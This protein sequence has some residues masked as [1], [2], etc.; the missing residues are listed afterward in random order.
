MKKLI[1]SPDKFKGTLTSPEI[2]DITEEQFKA[3]FPGLQ[4]IKL[5]IADGGDGTA[6]CF[7]CH[8]GAMKMPCKVSNPFFEL[9]D[10]YYVT[11][12]KT[13]VIETAMYAG[14]ALAGDRKNPLT[15][16]TYGVGQAALEAIKNGAE[17][18]IFAL[19]GS[20]TNDMGCGLLCAMGAKFYDK[21]KNAFIPTGKTLC[22]ICN[23]DTTELQYNTRNVEFEVM[24]DIDNVLF[25]KDGAAYVFAPQ[26]GADSQEVILLDRGL[27][28]LSELFTKVTGRDISSVAGAGAAGGMGAG[29]FGFLNATLRSGIEV[30]LDAV[31]FDNLLKDCDMV[32]T[33]EG[34]LD[35]QTMGGKVI[36]GIAKRCKKQNVRLVAICGDT[37]SCPEEIYDIGVTSVFSINT[38][39][40][41]FEQAKDFSRRNLTATVKNIAKLLN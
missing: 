3:Q 34:K 2:C 7:L 32:I 25:G 20:V 16:T 10:S 40:M 35:S 31:D 19:G 15:T 13:A 6:E 26:K 41:P 27:R 39:P 1:I 12:G 14:L 5:P 23:F 37:F 38:S 24:C 30:V 28:H 9:I 33:G 8:D 21:N 17:K 22:D 4:V 18:I 29:L 36:Y 11:V